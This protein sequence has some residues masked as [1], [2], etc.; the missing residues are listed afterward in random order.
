[1]AIPFLS[2]KKTGAPESASSRKSDPPFPARVGATE[3]LVD[4][5]AL[6]GNAL[7]LQN[8]SFVRMLE[9][10]PV[11]LEHSEQNL[12]QHYWS[13]FADALR[14]L[15]PPIQAQ[16]VIAARPQ[17]IGEYLDRWEALA[18]DWEARAEQAPSA[19]DADRRQRMARSARETAAFLASEHGRVVP[20]EHRYL[21]V[22]THNPVSGLGGRAP[23]ALSNALTQRALETLDEHVQMVAGAFSLMELPLFEL[24]PAAMCQAL[25][26][27]YHHP[28]NVLGASLSAG[29]LLQAP[30]PGRNA[31]LPPAREEF[32]A[33]A[34]DPERLADLLAPAL[35]EETAS[36]VRVGEVVGRGFRMHDFDPR[37]PV[38][39]GGVLSFS[40]DVTHALYIW[41]AD[42]V[43]MRQ[44]A[45]QRETEAMAAA[46]RDAERGAL[47]NHGNLHQIQSLS[48]Q[49]EAMEV[50]LESPLLLQW[51][52]VVWANDVPELEKA[53]QR[54]ET[55]LKLRDIRYYPATR[56]QLGA[57]QTVRP[58]GRLHTPLKARNMTAEALGPFF[59]FIRREYMDPAGWHFGFHRANGLLICV[60]PMEGGRS[61][62]SE[63]VIG[64]PRSGKS[65]YMKQTISS[66]LTLGHRVFVIDP[67]G[68][69]LRL[70]VDFHAPY[71]ELGKSG[72]A[73]SIDW[74]AGQADPV[75]HAL[76]R[77]GELYHAVSG[78]YLADDQ[79]LRLAE[80]YGAALEAAGIVPGDR[81][82]YT[83]TP[84]ALSAIGALLAAQ[85]DDAAAREVARV[86]GYVERLGGAN[87][88]NI[89]DINLDGDDP[90]SAG[91]DTLVAFY[92]ALAETRLDAEGR[93]ALLEGYSATLERWG[94]QA[95]DR[96]TWRRVP[97]LS[98]LVDV[99]ATQPAPRSREM[100]R[101]L[102]EYARGLYADLFNQPST[103][104][105]R[106]AQC[107]VFGV[108]RLRR[109]LGDRLAGV[110][111]WQIL[112]VVWNEITTRGAQH[113]AVHLFI[114]EAWYVLQYPGA[115]QRLLQMVRSAPKYSAAI[116]LANQDVKAMASSPDA[117]I[118]PDLGRLRVLFHQSADDAIAA[119][120]RMFGLAPAEQADLK[121]LRK[122][123]ALLLV[124]AET[125]LPIQCAV[126][127]ARLPVLA[128]NQAQ[129]AGMAAA[130][131]RRGEPVL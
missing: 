8:G 80:S 89:M 45:K 19:A 77:L 86:L 55:Q 73:R 58:V 59:P 16:I 123:Q 29:Q 24:D 108:D 27:A 13:L 131:G 36:Y 118:I 30:P 35:I 47:V 39:F 52:C 88:L 5:L 17:D 104:D 6:I 117:S 33:A 85:P 60:D 130:R 93:A 105:V 111:I 66:L 87:V 34:R 114:D 115:V 112:R 78:R 51:Y 113:Q 20:M 48:R 84:P 10:A 18:R 28:A 95:G 120:G 54:F 72:T 106:Q 102:N 101:V 25:W 49:R 7:V 103:V 40:G 2:R 100:A 121:H 83:R 70:A 94:V 97:T 9:V 91:A 65:V 74:D 53:C 41:P 129:M 11:D 68:E 127:A 21:V 82:T 15:R 62:G 1:M 109:T 126:D 71:V 125:R 42:P 56:R 119:L 57:L 44:Q 122:G 116:H 31:P 32:L 38:D 69:Y 67:H 79:A 98:A 75:V 76:A 124:G 81:T 107:V 90:W 14:R 23:E 50:A 110:F 128:S 61:N 96:A 92:E 63:L 3:S 99:L 4:I 64:E 26:Q 43:D 46:Y 12:R 37:R 22:V